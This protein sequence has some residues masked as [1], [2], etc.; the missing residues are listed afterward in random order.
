[1][2][3]LFH[4]KVFF[5]LQFVVIL[6]FALKLLTQEKMVPCLCLRGW[7]FDQIL[8][9]HTCSEKVISRVILS[10]SF[11]ISLLL[12]L[13]IRRSETI[14]TLLALTKL[15][16]SI[17]LNILNDVATFFLKWSAEHAADN[18]QLFWIFLWFK[19]IV[20][21][22]PS[23]LGSI[24]SLLMVSIMFKSCLWARGNNNY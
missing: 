6:S 12:F 19:N 16:K 7:S 2:S 11:V 8:L 15:F 20:I 3:S 18:S 22:D 9:M 23:F 1:M 13:V 4:R 14:S 10:P 5:K 21:I 24:F 17:A